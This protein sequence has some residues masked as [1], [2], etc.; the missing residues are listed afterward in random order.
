MLSSRPSYSTNTKD[1][2]VSFLRRR[3]LLPRKKKK[4]K[5][6]PSCFLLNVRTQY[7]QAILMRTYTG[8]IRLSVY[9]QIRLS[10]RVGRSLPYT[11]LLAQPRCLLHLA[12][13]LDLSSCILFRLRQYTPADLSSSRPAY[14]PHCLLDLAR[15]KKTSRNKLQR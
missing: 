7:A 11:F 9:M 10:D 5:D 13:P 8:C 3:G 2:N 1:K 14:I 4:I 15:R 12:I 6:Y